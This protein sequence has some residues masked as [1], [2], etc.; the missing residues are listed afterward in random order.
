ML[1][2]RAVTEFPLND[3]EIAIRHLHQSASD[4]VAEYEGRRAPPERSA[5]GPAG[6]DAAG[7][8]CSR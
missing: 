4:Y 2:T 8:S 3:Q 1:A 5:A 6:Q 7:R